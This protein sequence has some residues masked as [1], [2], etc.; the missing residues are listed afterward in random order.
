MNW[1]MLTSRIDPSLV[2]LHHTVELYYQS[3]Q[4][5]CN[6]T[7]VPDCCGIAWSFGN[8]FFASLRKIG[9]R[10]CSPL[11]Y[12]FHS[13]QLPTSTSTKPPIHD[14]FWFLPHNKLIPREDH[15]S[16]RLS[17]FSWRYLPSWPHSLP[18]PKRPQLKS[19][20]PRTPLLTTTPSIDEGLPSCSF[21]P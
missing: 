17:A 6:V 12:Q 11:I 3:Y 7:V 20:V 2:K 4:V 18:S 8:A 10:T 21:Q 19:L 9:Y 16:W 15:S 1:I 13:L 14:S 5:S